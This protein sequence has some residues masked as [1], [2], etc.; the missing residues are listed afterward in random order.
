MAKARQFGRSGKGLL[1]QRFFADMYPGL[2]LRLRW[3]GNVNQFPTVHG[4]S[5]MVGKTVAKYFLGMSL[6]LAMALV[7]GC[8]GDEDTGVAAISQGRWGHTATLL[9]DGRVLVV[10]GQE[11]PSRKLDTAE[12]FDPVAGTWSSAGS[13]SQK[14]GSGHEAIRLEDGRVLVL[15]EN[16]DG[17]AEIYDPSSG[18]WSSAG[19]ML[20]A[21]QWLATTL[22]DDGR[23]LVTGGLDASKAG[24]EELDTAEIYDSSTG[25]WTETGSMELVHAGHSAV[26]LDGKVLVVGKTL[27]ELYDPSTGTWSPAGKP[28]RER[29]L[30]TTADVLEDGRVLVTGGQFQQGGWTG[31]TVPIRNAEIYDPSS[32]TWTA[33]ESMSEPRE[34]HPSARLRDGTVLIIGDRATE[35]YD[36]ATN[37]WTSTDNMKRSRGDLSTA[38]LLNDGRVLVVGGK[39]ETDDGLRGVADVEIY[40]P[41]TGW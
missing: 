38:T 17:S 21:R 24:R 20:E 30:G 5:R 27:A 19:V 36:P 26:K 28:V 13:M 7:A 16:D 37:E 23:V 35:T 34:N 1:H 29:A 40:D 32:G 8:G 22:L 10:G 2:Q 31:V 33:V 6:V 18:Q 3:V 39:N 4:G 14:R 41:A 15:G 11:S 25:E 9:E 12:I